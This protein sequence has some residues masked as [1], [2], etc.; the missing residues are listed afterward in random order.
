[1]RDI[2][3]YFELELLLPH[4]GNMYEQ[5]DIMISYIWLFNESCGLIN[6]PIDENVWKIVN[7]DIDEIMEI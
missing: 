2:K 6:F 1:M 4:W 5:G 7:I 3:L